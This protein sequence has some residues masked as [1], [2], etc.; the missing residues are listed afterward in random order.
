MISSH[1]LGQG[2]S[3]SLMLRWGQSVVIVLVDLTHSLLELLHKLHVYITSV[4]VWDWLW[5]WQ[6]SHT[7]RSI[8]TPKVLDLASDQRGCSELGA[9]YASI[10]RQSITIFALSRNTNFRRVSASQSCCQRLQMKWSKFKPNV[11]CS[12]HMLWKAQIAHIQIQ[13]VSIV[14]QGSY[15]SLS[16]TVCTGGVEACWAWYYSSEWHFSV[17]RVEHSVQ[18]H[19][20]R[21]SKAQIQ[22]APTVR[23]SVLTARGHRSRLAAWR[24]LLYNLSHLLRTY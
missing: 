18:Q 24:I 22:W 10:A 8:Q 6:V 16:C 1:G 17:S 2:R 20:E 3:P 12:I 11:T 7:Y 14:R 13:L 4:Q 19:L 21:C 23:A 9:S 15:R 5:A